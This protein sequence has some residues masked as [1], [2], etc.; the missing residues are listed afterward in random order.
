MK[1]VLHAALLAPLLL[2]THAWSVTPCN[3]ADPPNVIVFLADDL[4]WGDLGCYGHPK[5]QTPN[6]DRFAS[7]GVRFTQAYAACGVC[8]PSRSSILTGRT[9]YRNGVWRWLPVGNEAHLRESEITIPETLRPLGYQ[10]MHSGKWHLNGYFNSDEQP[11]PDDHGYDWWFA[12]QNNASP[13][14]KDPINFVRN[15]K[16][17]GPLE[18]FSAPLVAEEASS[19]LKQQRDPNRPFFITVWTHEPHLPIES[20]PKFQQLYSEIDNPGIRQHHG[21]VT[22]LDH[23]FGN[24]MKTVDELGLRDNTF[25]IFTS[26]NGPEGSGKGNLKNPQSQQNRTWGSTGGLRGR[27]RDSHEGGIRVPGIVRWPGKIRPGTVSDVPI[28]GSDIFTTVLEIAGAPVPS[29]RTI[30]GVNLLPACEGKEL[31]R[32]VPLFWRTHIAP[33]ASHAAMRIGDWKIVADQKL[34][35]FQL[36][37]I[38][39]DWKEENDLADEMPE[40]LAE[41]KAKFMEVWEGVENEGPKEWW[42]NQPEGGK[43]KKGPKL[44]DG[45]DKT[46]DF[47]VVK[48]ATVSRSE[49]GYLLDSGQSEG[50][51]LQKLDVPVQE[52]A[53]FRIQY[54]SVIDDVTKNACFCFGAEPVNDRLHKAGTLIGMGRHGAF[55]GSWAN[56]K[57]GASKLGNFAPTDMFDATV[58]I[59]LDHGKLILKVNETRIEHQLPS[60]L[61]SVDYV[62]IYAKNT[63]SEFSKITR[64]K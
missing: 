20:D 40:K 30:D 57:I 35:R 24:L 44:S 54:R 1:P 4:G 51:A 41:M 6:L 25:V 48:G 27:K 15:R 22:Q 12:T 18:G 39:K 32:S 23:A 42:V 63:K 11:Q 47:D 17:V 38:A 52:S 16:A 19:W 8:S 28:I 10:T 3:A 34:E 45:T 50:F 62:G 37:Q 5:I 53:T 60:N 21:N 2:L 26:D 64:V 55:D 56:V 59:D 29:D 49:L 58:T 46:G 33:P 43:R 36:Y 61:E 13:S 9:P 7:E 31:E 14:H